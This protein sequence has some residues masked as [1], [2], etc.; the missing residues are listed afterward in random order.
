MS[1][2][3]P[4]KLDTIWYTRCN[5]PTPL[6][7]SAQLGLYQEEFAGDGI[8]IK[9][10]QESDNPAEQDSHFEHTLPHSFRLGGAVPAIWA[11]AKGQ[12]TRVIGISWIDEY[13]A[14]LALPESGIRSA[15][16]LKGRKLGLPK[17]QGRDDSVDV[18]RASALRGL[19][20]ALET[21]GL[22][23]GDAEWVDVPSRR[24]ERDSSD[25]AAPDTSV[26]RRRS[27]SYTAVAHALVKGEVDAIYVKDVRGAET[28]HLLGARVVTDL[29]FHPDPWV[30]VNNST[31]RPL[32]INA[33]TL[34]DHPD[35][36]RR[37]LKRIAE[38]DSWARRNPEEAVKQI[39][40]ETNWTESWVTFA[41]GNAVHESLGVDLQEKSV[42]GLTLFK[43]FLF[44]W[45]FIRQDFN[46]Q[47]WIDPQPLRSLHSEAA[48]NRQVA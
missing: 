1:A 33:A 15:K 16:D 13:Q 48:G 8:T 37:F 30:H 34:K 17:R 31:P 45:G 47:D 44:Q 10:L 21:A 3:T 29:G 12:D 26:R 4:R 42:K 38:V 23:H 25:I 11:R 43:D 9:S 40:R 41:Y 14:I 46:I 28:A 22:G 32:T 7:I 36:V 2:T 35:L 20:V 6:G 5:I 18:A 24:A 39:A 27:H 19:L